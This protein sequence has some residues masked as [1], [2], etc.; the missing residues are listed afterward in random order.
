[1]IKIT[2]AFVVALFLVMLFVSGS[3]G[4]TTYIVQPSSEY[5]HLFGIADTTQSLIAVGEYQEVVFNYALGDAYD[6]TVDGNCLL[7]EK[8]G[9]YTASFE[10]FF[11]DNSPVATSSVAIIITQDGAEVPGSYSEVD[12]V[13]QYANLELDTFAHIDANIGT[14]I[15]MEWTGSEASVSLTGKNTYSDQPLVAKGIIDW[16]HD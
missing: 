12:F 10:L 7:V 2:I 8:K 15:C 11:Q 3:S 6:F 16:S 5:P 13:K 14:R 4:D 9:R 1:M